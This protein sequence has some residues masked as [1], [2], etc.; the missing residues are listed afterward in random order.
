MHYNH[1]TCEWVCSAVMQ[2]LVVTLA[3]CEDDWRGVPPFS[4]RS[5]RNN[6]SSRTRRPS[7]CVVA[8]R[9]QSVSAPPASS[10]VRTI[11]ECPGL[12]Q[13][14]H[15]QVSSQHSAFLGLSKHLAWQH[16]GSPDYRE[17]FLFKKDPFKPPILH[18]PIIPEKKGHSVTVSK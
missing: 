14:T 7:D 17:R 10:P 3:G 12:S 6:D 18:C 9:A 13:S 8:N 16:W 2:L 11:T 1:H 15:Q 4:V 5:C